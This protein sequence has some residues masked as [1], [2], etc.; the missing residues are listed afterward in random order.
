M[1]ISSHHND[2]DAKLPS[3][4][5]RSAGSARSIFSLTIDVEAI[6]DKL[7]TLENRG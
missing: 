1:P 3:L 4:R 6:A 5:D 7:N 2:G